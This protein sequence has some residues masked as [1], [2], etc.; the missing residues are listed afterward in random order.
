M[1]ATKVVREECVAGQDPLARK[2]FTQAFLGVTI[3]SPE[4]HR[5]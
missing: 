5:E 3:F 4:G 1:L 2:I